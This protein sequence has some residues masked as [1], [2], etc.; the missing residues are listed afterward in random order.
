[1]KIKNLEKA[2]DERMGELNGQLSM[3]LI[4]METYES[5]RKYA[6]VALAQLKKEGKDRVWDRFFGRPN[7]E[8]YEHDKE[9]YN[10]VVSFARYSKIAVQEI[11]QR[12][13]IT[14]EE[15]F[16]TASFRSDQLKSILG[17]KSK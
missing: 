8:E 3:N 5:E 10:S 9:L 7:L 13:G 17:K 14:E 15:V 16:S 2:F 4:G 11:A 1:M 6:E 12:F